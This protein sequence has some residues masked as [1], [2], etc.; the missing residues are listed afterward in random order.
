MVR[1]YISGSD[2][3]DIV[4]IDRIMNTEKCCHILIKHAIPQASTCKCLIG[5]CFI[6][7]HENDS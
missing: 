7:Q 5:R 1:G 4:K 3:K 2:I 6:S